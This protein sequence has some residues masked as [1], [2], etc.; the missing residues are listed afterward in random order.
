MQSTKY[1]DKQNKTRFELLFGWTHS[2]K[3]SIHFIVNSIQFNSHTQSH[4][5]LRS[6]N[7]YVVI[8]LTECAMKLETHAIRNAKLTRVLGVQT[9]ALDGH[10]IVH[11]HEYIQTSTHCILRYTRTRTCVRNPIAKY[12]WK[13]AQYVL[14]RWSDVLRVF[15]RAF[16]WFVSEEQWKISGCSNMM[17]A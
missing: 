4:S 12:V 10:Q 1:S 2:R 13:P 8:A 5:H 7:S 3:C 11:W 17:Y 15:L 16:E 14:T 9:H 6:E